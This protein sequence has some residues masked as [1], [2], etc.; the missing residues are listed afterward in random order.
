MSKRGF[1][2]PV[3]T[4]F[5]LSALFI[6]MSCAGQ[7][8]SKKASLDDLGQES[9]SG[10]PTEDAPP[11]TEDDLAAIDSNGSAEKKEEPTGL[12]T[13]DEMAKTAEADPLDEITDTNKENVAQTAEPEALGDIPSDSPAAE[14]D[15]MANEGDLSDDA[16]GLPSDAD[17]AK[18]EIPTSN[19]AEAFISPPVTETAR[20]E[21]PWSGVSRLPSIPTAAI[22]RKGKT[23]NRFYFLRKGDTAASVSDLLYGSADQ[24]KNLRAWNGKG[25]WKPGKLIF[26]ASAL[27]P[28]DKQM[29]SFYKERGIANGE[30]TVKRGDWLSKVATQLL[31]SP[32]SWKEI[33]IINGLSSADAIKKGQLLAVYPADLRGGAT[34][35]AQDLESPTT[36]AAQTPPA[37]ADSFQPDSDL[38][39]APPVPPGS[40]TKK[41]AKKGGMNALLLLEQE[42]ITILFAFIGIVFLGAL[43][44]VNKRRKARRAS[45]AEEVNEDVFGSGSN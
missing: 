26:Y 19:S 11:S 23:L 2:L 38:Q 22:Q 8:A 27:A 32:G 40:P 3:L 5:L 10:E 39:I 36:A 28:A 14:P 24:Q 17:F 35:P 34:A 42:K 30:Y 41:I 44:M 33:A 9:V 43:L 1:I 16:L 12:P 7:E 21:Q 13:E 6:F 37:A 31:G 45:V 25:D 20:V 15:K 29:Q 4:A 18:A